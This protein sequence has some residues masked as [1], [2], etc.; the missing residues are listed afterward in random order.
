MMD[1][2]YYARQAPNHLAL[3]APDG[4]HWSRVELLAE[5]RRIAHGLRALGMTPADR[6]V[7][8]LPNCA[9][10]IAL[11]LGLSHIGARLIAV[12][13]QAGAAEV[14]SL[15]RQDHVRGFISH[16][17]IAEA[18][19]ALKQ[20]GL[21][22]ANAFSVGRL[23]GF[24]P[25]S[26]LLGNPGRSATAVAGTVQA[27]TAAVAPEPQS[28]N[29]LALFDIPRDGKNVHFCGSPLQQAEV[30]AWAVAALHYGH[31]V[32]LAQQ[33]D[34]R[35]MLQTIDQYRVSSSLMTQQQFVDMLDLPGEVRAHYDVSSLRHIIHHGAP[36]PEH[37]RRA[38]LD[39]WG[40]CI[41]ESAL[42]PAAGCHD[43]CMDYS[44][45]SA[46]P[47]IQARRQDGLKHTI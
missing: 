29:V 25:W 6:V 40:P 16:G 12:D 4:R 21:H 20:A 14:A 2:E 11:A 26:D 31:A 27:A 39:W 46:A 22:G 10:F 3:A 5:S 45:G 37:I 38:M 24:R 35:S 19:P 41:Y 34:A 47:E 42:S 43:G 33:W 18:G 28:S 7:A 32:V 15:L 9:E 8:M 13:C 44:T 36:L 1:F 17:G 23:P 30:M